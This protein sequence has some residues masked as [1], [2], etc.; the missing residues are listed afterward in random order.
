MNIFGPTK[1]EMNT[2]Y[3]QT[4]AVLEPTEVNCNNLKIFLE[5]LHDF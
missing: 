1:A 5:S 4:F 3:P 2:L